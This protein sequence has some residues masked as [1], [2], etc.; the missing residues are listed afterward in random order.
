[1]HP[2]DIIELLLTFG[3]E[4]RVVTKMANF[5]VVDCASTYNEILGRPTLH[6][7]KA[8]PST[9]HQSMK[10]LTKKELE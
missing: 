9:Y 10:F 5:L 3:E 7:L 6:E 8:I 1:M 2:K 4:P